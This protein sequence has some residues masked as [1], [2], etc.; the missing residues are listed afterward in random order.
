MMSND[1]FV[2]FYQAI[3]GETPS[4]Q[5]IDEFHVN[6][7]QNAT[8]AREYYERIAQ[9][10]LTLALKQGDDVFINTGALAA[11]VREIAELVLVGKFDDFGATPAAAALAISDGLRV[12]VTAAREYPEEV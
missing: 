1:D 9:E 3:V 6:E 12:M 2:E 11:Y 8:D 4:Q 7:I 5:D 10:G